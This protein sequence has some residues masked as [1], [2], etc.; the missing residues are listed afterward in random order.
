LNTQLVNTNKT[1]TINDK[2]F[3]VY[4]LMNYDRRIK[5]KLCE[6]LGINKKRLNKLIKTDEDI[7]SMYNNL[8]EGEITNETY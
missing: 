3:S 7:K 6:I 1:K 2:S 4:E 5:T 8:K